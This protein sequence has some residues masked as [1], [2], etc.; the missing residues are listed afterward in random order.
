MRGQI[1]QWIIQV[2]KVNT[3][4]IMMLSMFKAAESIRRGE[5]D[6]LQWILEEVNESKMEAG[7]KETMTPK[8]LGLVEDERKPKPKPEVGAAS[9]GLGRVQ[10]GTERGADNHETVVG[11]GAEKCGGRGRNSAETARSLHARVEEAYLYN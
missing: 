4:L 8:N 2:T 7:W 3:E 9:E 11:R 10:R 1:A 6:P 5:K